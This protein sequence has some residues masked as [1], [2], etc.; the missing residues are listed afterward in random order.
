MPFMKS[1][2]VLKNKQNTPMR[3][4]NFLSVPSVAHW[5]SGWSVCLERIDER[6]KQD[7]CLWE[8]GLAWPQSAAP[9]GNDLKKAATC[10]ED[11]RGGGKGGGKQTDH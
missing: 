5:H 2:S 6:Q 8:Q 3:S 7:G 10:M 1:D 11:F 9:P 4:S